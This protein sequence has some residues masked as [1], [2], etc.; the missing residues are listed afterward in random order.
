[1]ELN[2]KILSLK[3]ERANVTTKMREI[4]GLSG[5]ALEARREDLGNLEMR[6]DVLGK[7][8]ALAEKLLGTQRAAG[9]HSETPENRA[10]A[11]MKAFGSFI[12]SQDGAR[13]YRAFAQGTPTQAGYLV[14]PMNFVGEVIRGLDDEVFI[15]KLAK[16]LVPSGIGPFVSLGIPTRTTAAS[17][18]DW[19]GEIGSLN[20]ETTLTYGRREFKANRL[21]K[22]AKISKLLLATSNAEAEIKREI[23]YKLGVTQEKGYLVG[24]GVGQPLGVFTSSADG[25]STGRDIVGSNTATAIAADTIL[26][27]Y[28]AIKAQYQPNL[29]WIGHRDFF[30]A[31]SKLK[32]GDGQF[33][34][35]PSLLPG[36]P[37]L[38]KGKPVMMSEYAPNTFTASQYV[39]ILG[40]FGRGYGFAD[41]LNLEIQPLWELYAG[42]AQQ[43]YAFTY[44]GDGAPILEEAFARIQLHA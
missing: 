2:E 38:L 4:V 32:T 10:T 29:S 22:L 44:Y 42:N 17:D 15:R 33:L 1:M 40:D 11:E 9:E 7:D 19:T 23:L 12:R 43:G 24:N 25:I 27:A 16:N 41:S 14:A 5:D 30:K 3:D 39:G 6:F 8:I 13:E 34:W 21:S 20:D 35:Q 26:D 37:D 28:Y 18:A 31:V 36:Q